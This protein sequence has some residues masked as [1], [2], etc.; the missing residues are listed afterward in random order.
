MRT[1]PVGEVLGQRRHL[2]PQRK[3]LPVL[4]ACGL[5]LLGQFGWSQQAAETSRPET[6]AVRDVTPSSPEAL[7]AYSQAATY[8]NNRAFDL[9]AEAWQ[10]FLEAYQDDPK[11]VDARYNLGVCYLELKDFG[12]ARATLQGRWTEDRTFLDARMPF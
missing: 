8:Q 6:A 2:P 11:S 7:S 5:A 12:K 10:K 1:S 3:W 9:A 4:V